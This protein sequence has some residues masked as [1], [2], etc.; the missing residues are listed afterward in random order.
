MLSVSLVL[1]KSVLER[2]NLSLCPYSRNCSLHLLYKRIQHVPSWSFQIGFVGTGRKR[3]GEKGGFGICQHCEDFLAQNV[4][5]FLSA[6]NLSSAK[7]FINQILSWITP[8][9]SFS[10]QWASQMARSALF[11]LQSHSCLCW[12]MK[13]E[14]DQLGCKPVTCL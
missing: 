13:R 6:L 14:G 12:G 4:G 5:P 7:C 10:L 11:S 3:R 2:L 1:P 9:Q 8:G